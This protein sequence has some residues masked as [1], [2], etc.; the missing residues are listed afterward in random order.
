MVAASSG[1]TARPFVAA[2][3]QVRVPGALV[4][5]TSELLPSLSVKSSEGNVDGARESVAGG[6]C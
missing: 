5:A 1:S 4:N 6:C 2:P 3:V